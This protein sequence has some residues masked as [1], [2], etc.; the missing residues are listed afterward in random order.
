MKRL[1]R[2]LPKAFILIAIAALMLAVACGPAATPT[3]TPKPTPTAT[4]TATP[5][6][7]APTPTPAPTATPTPLPPGVPTPTPAPTPTPTPV[8]TA[9]TTPRPAP[10]ATPT[11]TATVAVVKP[12]GTLRVALTTV[13]PAVWDPSKLGPGSS[14]MWHWGVNETPSMVN[15][16]DQI[17]QGLAES[18]AWDS[19]FTT[20]TWKLRKGIQFQGG[21]GEMTADD[22]EYTLLAQGAPGNPRNYALLTEKLSDHK[23]L[24]KYT[25]QFVLKKRDPTFFPFFMINETYGSFAIWPK[26]RADTLGAD[27]MVTDISFG[28]GPFK[29]TKY[30]QGNEA[31]LQAVENHWRK[32]P[33]FAELRIVAMPE[34]ATQVAA[35]EAGELDVVASVPVPLAK[36]LKDKGFVLGARSWGGKWDIGVSGQFCITEW[37]GQ[38]IPPREAYDPTKPWIGKCDDTTSMER[39]RKVRLAMAYSL[40]RDSYVNDLLTGF[41]KTTF[42]PEIL[43]PLRQRYASKAKEWNVPYDVAKSKALLAEAGYPSGFEIAFVLP[44]PVVAPGEQ[45]FEAV[46]RDL[47]AVGIKVKAQRLDSVA[48]SKLRDSRTF[49]GLALYA[50]A[51]AVRQPEAVRL[52]RLPTAT[53]NTGN[54]LPD[55]LNLALKGDQAPT[56]AEQAAL[57]EQL[58]GYFAYW[59]YFISLFEMDKLYAVNPKKVG[60]WPVSSSS[61]AVLLSY[62]YAERVK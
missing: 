38:K 35:L 36:R 58:V 62:E 28:T 52:R 8:P 5:A 49:A 31:V 10:T 45:V 17:I 12:T 33:E 21:W 40:N 2:S 48:W 46:M 50:N 30:E 41:G 53:F 13:P 34:S 59:Q 23:A 7:P 57:V 55:A 20:L 61:E 14:E 25:Y 19:S 3:P 4:P 1:S 39:A 27:K 9:T 6:P 16:L 24:D 18:W 26:K 42:A 47:E 44:T 51:G 22:W 15:E 43:G 32:T 60:K 54:E 11:P 56:E 37:Q 29:L